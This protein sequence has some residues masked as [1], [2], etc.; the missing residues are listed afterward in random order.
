MNQE[1]ERFL[2]SEME[3]NLYEHVWM[4][5]GF[6]SYYVSKDYY[7][8]RDGEVFILDQPGIWSPS[9]D[10]L[11][12]LQKDCQLIGKYQTSENL[13]RHKKTYTHSEITE[14]LNLK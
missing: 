3:G 6:G 2:A 7:M 5:F 9:K 4:T 13:Q 11:F 10:K 12:D 1:I 8:V 14:L